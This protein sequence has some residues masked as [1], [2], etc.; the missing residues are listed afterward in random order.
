MIGSASGKVGNVVYAV[1]N[2]IQVA[3][4]YQPNVANPKSEGQ[5]EQRLKMVL[6]GRLS[7][8]IP[9]DAILGFL[10]NARV[11]R[12]KFIS[13]VVKHA[14][15]TAAN[16]VN[17]ARVPLE[18]ILFS[19]GPLDVFSVAQVVT[20]AHAQTNPNIISVA[21]AASVLGVGAP[22]G[23]G[24]DIVAM[25]VNAETSQF[26]YAK[27]VARDI[28]NGNNIEFRVSDPHRDYLV[29]VYVIPRAIDAKKGRMNNSYVGGDVTGVNV[30]ETMSIRQ[31]SYFGESH[32]VAA[33]ML[34]AVAK[35]AE[36]PDRK[37][38]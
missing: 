3:R 2:G 5:I 7:K 19:E 6:A 26:D 21:V 28:T 22:A 13:N 32:L 11:R 35:N 8:I 24:E 34:A 17:T 33:T 36:E 14:V 30:N 29:A 16:G 31:S 15:L 4:I 10:G 25:L 37:G 12:G 9:A 18:D 1:T 20:A 23:Y 27:V 38:K